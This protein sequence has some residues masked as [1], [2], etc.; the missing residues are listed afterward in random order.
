MTESPMLSPTHE[1]YTR[2]L[3]VFSKWCNLLSRQYFSRQRRHTHS[4]NIVTHSPPNTATMFWFKDTAP[5]D[6]EIHMEH[7]SIY[8]NLAPSKQP[9]K[10]QA[11]R[12]RKKHLRNHLG[13]LGPEPKATSANKVDRNTKFGHC[14]ETLA[15]T[16]R[17]L[18][19]PKGTLS[20]LTMTC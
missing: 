3:C 1:K 16:R 14:A 6:D 2:L 20:K 18:R 5:T 9:A 7:F 12:I 11:R 19:Y 8:T 15:L 13:H 10:E 4:P 17:V